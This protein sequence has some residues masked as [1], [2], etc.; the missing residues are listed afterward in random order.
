MTVLAGT[1]SSAPA[2]PTSGPLVRTHRVG[3]RVVIDI[4]EIQ[5][6]QLAQHRTRT[7]G[8]ARR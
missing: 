8:P 5:G 4:G 6:R 3:P 1:L 2:E 7:H